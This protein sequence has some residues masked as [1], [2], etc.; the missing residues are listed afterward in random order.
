MA[1][2]TAAVFLSL[3]IGLVATLMQWRRAETSARPRRG[4]GERSP[5]RRRLDW[6]RLAD[7]RLLDGLMI[8]A[9]TC[10]W[11]AAP[12]Q[13]PA[14]EVWLKKAGELA[15]RLPAHRAA[16]E[17]ARRARAHPY[18]EEAQEARSRI[19]RS[20]DG[21]ARRDRS[22]D[23]EPAGRSSPRPRTER[24]LRRDERKN[25]DERIAMLEGEKQGDREQ[26]LTSAC[27]GNSIPTRSSSSTISSRCS[28][29]TSTCSSATRGT[30]ARRGRTS[31]R[32]SSSRGPSASGR[33]TTTRRTGGET[34]S[35][36]ARSPRSTAGSAS[37][38]Q[39]G[40]VPLGPD[41]ATGLFE[42]AELQTGE[43]P[44][45]EPGKPVTMSP[46]TRAWSSS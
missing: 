21:E 26:G 9:D 17:A 4:V 11:P 10:L 20:G 40:L 44:V 37:S 7:G 34:I 27:P 6:E 12:E 23:R 13:I 25:A 30:T 31:R 35:Q 42:F 29:G 18:G 41:P 46:E 15:D 2:M 24:A 45:R 28:S 33:S 32:A 36:I 14:M 43:P 16:L 38:E 3:A 8:D 1:V 5:P 22:R 19:V 39:L